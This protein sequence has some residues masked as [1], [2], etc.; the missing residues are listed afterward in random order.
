MGTWEKIKEG[1]DGSISF[2]SNPKYENFI[3]STNASAVIVSKTFEPKQRI[4][5]TS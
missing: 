2:L 4:N 1:N 3:Y 5:T